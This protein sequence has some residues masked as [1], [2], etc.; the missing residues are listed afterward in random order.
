MSIEGDLFRVTVK[1]PRE[2]DVKNFNNGLAAVCVTWDEWGFID[3]TGREVT[4][5]RY[6]F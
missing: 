6:T 3:K 2:S 5:F 1:G 4:P